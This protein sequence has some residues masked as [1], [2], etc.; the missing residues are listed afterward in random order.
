MTTLRV[1]RRTFL[2][3][4]GT[5]AGGLV[6]GCYV[7]GRGKPAAAAFVRPNGYVRIDADGATT[8][9][10]KNPDMGQ[11]SKTSL[12]MMVAEE[13]DADWARVKVEQ[14][15]L[16]RA[17]YG[18]QGAGGSDGT[19]SD[20]PLCRKAGAAARALLVAAAA[21]TWGVDARSCSTAK[22]VV[23][24]RAS[25]RALEYGE[26]A[27]VAA[28]LPVPQDVPLKDPSGFT[29]IGRPIPGV[30]TPR[31]VVG[32][33]IYGLDVRVPG[34]LRAVVEKCPVHG[35]RP[36]KVD[37]SDTLKVAGVKQVVTI[38]GHRNPTFLRPGVAVV[39]DSTW[40]AM[41]GRESLRVTWDEGEG[42]AESSDALSSQFRDLAR[43]AGKVLGEAG[44][45]ERAFAA[46]PTKVDVVYEAPFLAHAT[47]EPQNCVA[48][49]REGRCEIW[50]PLQMPTSGAGVVAQAIGIPR[51]QVVI[52]V[53]RL[54]GGFGRRLLSDYAAEA[55]WV[56][57]AVGAPVQV[58]WTREDDTRHDYY[59][60][61]GFHH[62]RAALDARGR[63]VVWHHH[64]VCV[65][66]N[67][68]RGDDA[69]PESTE[70]YGLMA[71]RTDDLRRQLSSDLVPVLIPNCRLEFSEA[72]TSVPTGA[73]R[74]PAHNVNAYVIESVL[75]EL[76]HQGGVD[77]VALRLSYLGEPHDLPYHG[78][79]PAP[80]NP[81]RVKGVLRLAAEK[82]G[83]GAPLS[84]GRGRGVAVH[85]TFGSYC[86]HVA[87]VTVGADGGVHVDRVVSAIDVGVPVNPLNLEAQ[88]QGGVIDGLGAAL[89]GEITIADGRTVQ[90]TFDDY[91][92]IRNREAPEIDVHIVPSRE[93]S[94]GFGEIALPPIAP[95]VAN[96]IFAATGRRIRRLPLLKEL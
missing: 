20:G 72:K 7:R 56:S 46:A 65:S 29:I 68:Y 35:G 78:D 54:G 66:R 31:I 47:L 48:D 94:T 85:F 21:K 10:A 62:V 4:A 42:R 70:I 6:V 60:P 55:A 58:V 95:A 73:W 88:T 87:E 38:E 3:V 15:D 96:A 33:P 77:P 49:V 43:R 22:G 18:G 39:A 51:E 17:L 28:T 36:V 8:I 27:A 86:A 37:A 9:W 2:T 19:P 75:D 23:H 64:L 14:A 80:Y 91:P 71:P 52:H 16:N 81:D 76:A 25:G 41:K 79:D 44:D 24:H 1:D 30:D 26:L 40:A 32:E 45:V 90:S 83:W 12:P 50:G 63:L 34:M 53:T 93:A 92:L 5:A 57:K 84:R 69:P 11:G 74:A 61:A 59:R 82:A 89:H 13:L 67:R